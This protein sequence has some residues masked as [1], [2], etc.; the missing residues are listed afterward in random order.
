MNLILTG[1]AV[2]NVFNGTQEVGSHGE[3][4]VLYIA[5]LLLDVGTCES[6][7]NRSCCLKI[8]TS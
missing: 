3:D 5:T 8:N 6:H 4:K 1:V 2:S 7:S